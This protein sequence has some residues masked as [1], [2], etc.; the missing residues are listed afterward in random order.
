M[1]V[2]DKVLN[3]GGRP[4]K[5]ITAHE[6]KRQEEIFYQGIMNQ[7]EIFEKDYESDDFAEMKD[8]LIQRKKVIAFLIDKCDK[9]QDNTGYYKTKCK[10]ETDRMRSN[11]T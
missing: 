1:R 7:Q 9:Q 6:R 4:K 3:K 5:A 11:N 8:E 10:M 2:Q